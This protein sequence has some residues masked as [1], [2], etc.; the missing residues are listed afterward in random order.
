MCQGSDE[1]LV[2]K[3]LLDQDFYYCLVSR[4]EKPLKRYINRMT[5]L[6][7]AEIEDVLQDVFLKAYLNLNDFDQSLKFSSWIYRLTHNEVI[8]NHR[9][10]KVRQLDSVTSLDN[11]KEL[12]DKFSHEENLDLKISSEQLQKVLSGLDNKYREI[13]ELKFLEEKSYNEIS[14]ILE[15]P[16]GTVA[17]LINRAKKQF[18]K[19]AKDKNVKF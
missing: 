18:K 7:E 8:D 3:T 13:L 6:R 4:Y 9:K 16:L 12:V 19:V 15:K 1:E 2:V 14:D 11:W 17:T 10:R 5:N